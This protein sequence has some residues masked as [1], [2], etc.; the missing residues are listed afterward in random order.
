MFK[1][2]RDLLSIGPGR[3]IPIYSRLEHISFSGLCYTLLD[4][5]QDVLMKTSEGYMSLRTHLEEVVTQ[6]VHTG[7][8]IALI[9]RDSTEARLV[10]RGGKVTTNQD[11]IRKYYFSGPA[12]KKWLK[13]IRMNDRYIAE[14]YYNI[15]TAIDDLVDRRT[16]KIPKDAISLR[17][18]RLRR[19]FKA[20]FLTQ[21]GHDFWKSCRAIFQRVEPITGA[22][23]ILRNT[24]AFVELMVN[25]SSAFGIIEA[26]TPMV[27]A[28]TKSRR[29]AILR[30][31]RLVLG[32]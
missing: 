26:G 21:L 16:R 32:G 24:N 4:R 18:E 20:L 11:Y 30:D 25:D 13:E 9:P 6:A 28:R 23:A 29:A 27:R 10:G 5:G 7:R 17:D 22:E 8:L 3:S 2:K 12:L 14:N 15:V 31:V 19:N 1:K